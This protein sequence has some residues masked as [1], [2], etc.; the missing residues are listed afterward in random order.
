MGL[1]NQ[2]QIKKLEIRLQFEKSSILAKKLE[3]V[4]KMMNAFGPS[5]RAEPGRIGVPKI[6]GKIY[7]SK[8]FYKIS[9]PL[10]KIHSSRNM[11]TMN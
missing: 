11:I 8:N 5:V 9:P 10:K 6:F 4:G 1:V 2:T 7:Y 3:R